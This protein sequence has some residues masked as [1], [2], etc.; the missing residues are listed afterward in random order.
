MRFSFLEWKGMESTFSGNNFNLP[1]VHESV[2]WFRLSY[3]K[4]TPNI[5]KKD[6]PQPLYTHDHIIQL[7][8]TF[9]MIEVQLSRSTLQYSALNGCFFYYAKQYN[10]VNLKQNLQPKQRNTFSEVKVRIKCFF[11]IFFVLFCSYFQWDIQFVFGSNVIHARSCNK[12]I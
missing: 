3:M 7:I 8:K 10:L 1:T 6:S 4:Y 11:L 5:H 12:I 2:D 9:Q